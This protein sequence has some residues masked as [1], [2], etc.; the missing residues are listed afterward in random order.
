MRPIALA[1]AAYVAAAP[2]QAQPEAPSELNLALVQRC[3]VETTADELG[4]C[5]QSMA[6]MITIAREGMIALGVSAKVCAAKGTAQEI[7][8]CLDQLGRPG[9]VGANSGEMSKRPEATLPKGWVRAPDRESKID[10]SRFVGILL[11]ADDQL[12]TSA[13]RKVTPSLM[14]RCNDNVTSAFVDVPGFFVTGGV[15]VAYR[16]DKD[17]PISQTWLSSDN[18]SSVGLWE[19][20]LA[21]PFVKSLLGRE[22]FVF[23]FKPHNKANAEMTFALAG[24]DKAIEPIRAAC[25]W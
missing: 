13:G 20:G 7:R 9:A 23:R 6:R 3:V 25:K 2:C 12:T 8:D 4:K 16:L 14:I 1:L 10:G 21:I 19:G 18:H 17:R 11:F 24:L 22:E 15:A 5:V